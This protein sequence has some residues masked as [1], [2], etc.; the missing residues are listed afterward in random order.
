MNILEKLHWEW[1]Q[2]LL[3]L[4]VLG[5][6]PI[7]KA[8]ATILVG[9]FVKPEIAKIALPLILAA[10]GLSRSKPSKNSGDIEERRG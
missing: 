6:Y 9:R 7:F 1:W 4:L 2:V 5:M 8:F 3:L 10:R